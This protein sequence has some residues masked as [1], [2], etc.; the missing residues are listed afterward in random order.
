MSVFFLHDVEKKYTYT[1]K[2]I[3]VFFEKKKY[4]SNVRPVNIYMFFMYMLEFATSENKI[5]I[6]MCIFY[7]NKN[8]DRAYV[9]HDFVCALYQ[10]FVLNKTYINIGTL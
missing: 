7:F 10:C 9:G 8:I 6:Y 1:C 2:Y 4:M 5:H 3:Y